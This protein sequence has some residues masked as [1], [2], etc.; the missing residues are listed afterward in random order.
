MIEYAN[1]IRR[2]EHAVPTTEVRAAGNYSVE[3]VRI[4][5]AEHSGRL[6]AARD[7]RGLGC[8]E[9]LFVKLLE[10]RAAMIGLQRSPALITDEERRRKSA[11]IAALIAADQKA[12]RE[13]TERM[14]SLYSESF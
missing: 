9:S 14:R 8:P 12:E 10:R 13:E 3:E 11:Q 7:L 6:K 2:L 5:L 4:I 1:S